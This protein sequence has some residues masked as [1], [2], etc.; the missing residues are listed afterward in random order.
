M[1]QSK[2]LSAMR[3]FLKAILV[4]TKTNFNSD[5]SKNVRDY[6]GFSI[7]PGDKGQFTR[8]YV[9]GKIQHINWV[10]RLEHL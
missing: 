2:L 4:I 3:W 5:V 10:S 6:L 8:L 9:K 7:T 1:E